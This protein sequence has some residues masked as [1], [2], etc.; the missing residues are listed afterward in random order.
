MSR[1]IQQIWLLLS[2]LLSSL[3]LISSL[4]LDELE[5]ELEDKLEELELD[6]HLEGSLL[7][8]GWRGEILAFALD[9]ANEDGDA[10]GWRSASTYIA[11]W[12]EPQPSDQTDLKQWS[13]CIVEVGWR[14]PRK[15]SLT[16]R[17]TQ[18]SWP[19]MWGQLAPPVSLWPSASF[20]CL[21][22]SSRTFLSISAEFWLDLVQ[23]LDSYSFMAHSV[24][25][26]KNSQF[27]KAMKIVMLVPKTLAWWWF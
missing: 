14:P 4:Q 3:S 20:S 21:L 18:A 24:F 7:L 1:K 22:M 9:V 2:S 5:L 26:P 17:W 16:W 19:D 11:R 6:D 13:R 12:D 27:T 8:L 15:A 25:I 23:F 10:S